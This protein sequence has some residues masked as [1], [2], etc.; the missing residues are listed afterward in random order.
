MEKTIRIRAD[1]DPLGFQ[2]ANE[3]VEQ[4]TRSVERLTQASTR[5]GQG[6]SAGA[7]GRPG[8]VPPPAP[9]GAGGKKSGLIGDI[10]GV[11]DASALRSLVSGTDTALRST[12]S[13]VRTF[14]DRADADLAR[15][16]KRIV[17]VVSKMSGLGGGGGGGGGLDFMGGGGGKTLPSPL[18]YRPSDMELLKR[19]R[20]ATARPGGGGAGIG[21]IV[22]YGAGQLGF[23]GPTGQFMGMLGAAGGGAMV[24]G[25]VIGGAMLANQM[26]EMYVGSRE[27]NLRWT[28][29]EAGNVLGR[30]AGMVAPFSRL[31]GAARGGDAAYGAAFSKTINSRDFMQSIQMTTGMRAE[32]AERLSGYGNTTFGSLA[33]EISS[34]AGST[35][36]DILDK[37]GAT[38]SMDGVSRN[39][40][41]SIART[42]AV[43]NV[44]PEQ[45]AAFQ[46]GVEN[47]RATMDPRFAE[48]LNFVPG[49]AMSN[50]QTRRMGFFGVPKGREAM[51]YMRDLEGNYASSGRSAAEVGGANRALVMGAGKGYLRF[52]GS[53][54]LSMH[55]GGAS[56]VEQ[57]L[58]GGGIL[59]GSVGAGMSF[60]NRT[61]QHS[62]VGGGGLDVN[63]GSELFGSLVQR[64]LGLGNAFGAGDT[65]SKYTEGAAGLVYGG[66]EDTA[67][68]Q[69]N[70]GLLQRGIPQLQSLTQG[71]AAPLYGAL[72]L[73]N[74]TK[75]TGG[76][77]SL[78]ERLRKTDVT[79]LQ[80]IARGGSVPGEIMG[81][82]G[83]GATEATVRAMV[84]S[85]LAGV[86]RSAF[87]ESVSLI[88]GSGAEKLVRGFR[89]SN[90]TLPDYIGGLLD[91]TGLKGAARSRGQKRLLETMGGAALGGTEQ[92]FAM[93]GETA[94]TL[95]SRGV[96]GAGP[97]GLEGV[98]LGFHAEEHHREGSALRTFRDP[99]T[100]AVS[101]LSQQGEMARRG[102]NDAG[103]AMPGDA[104]IAFATALAR[105]VPVLQALA[106][107]RITLPEYDRATAPKRVAGGH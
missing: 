74:W 61:F 73:V 35:V 93:F 49:A 27:A 92:L 97:Q 82:A 60:V 45:A 57:M 19:E 54:L 65:F 51:E 30:S 79:V 24:A 29:G 39:L 42:V 28:T 98:G 90:Q 26:A 55:E 99:V 32:L 67:G 76:Y 71:T 9:G 56:G 20:Q 40:A 15:L 8:S 7:A 86:Q 53:S 94:P 96:G 106:D 83:P 2:R 95:H 12:G 18:D 77:S 4:L 52:G 78:T 64:S 34:G 63:A 13:G 23:G 47:T 105:A 44:G 50:L 100:G 41:A 25:G 107:R 66:G 89:G 81:L 102:V 103:S 21:Q 70:V 3:L 33:K 38:S 17:S 75:A 22:Q 101:I 1:V 10:L 91:S 31:F 58:R 62:G 46:Q 69:R 68:Q 88:P 16:E 43:R 85:G 11:S 36:Q 72:S 48:A 59:G 87:A 80:G 84:K 14:V 5:A 104:M 37:V 6:F